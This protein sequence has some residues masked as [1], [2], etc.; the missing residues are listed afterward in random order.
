MLAG[1]HR[2]P[3]KRASNRHQDLLKAHQTSA[4]EVKYGDNPKNSKF[5]GRPRWILFGARNAKALAAAADTAKPISAAE[6]E[7]GVERGRWL[8]LPG[9]SRQPHANL[10]ISITLIWP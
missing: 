7:P 6:D 10:K 3:R 9:A 8:S 1:G 2:N 4:K 5:D